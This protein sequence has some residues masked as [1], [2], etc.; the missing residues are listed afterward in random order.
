MHPSFPTTSHAMTNQKHVEQLQSLS[1]PTDIKTESEP[2]GEASDNSDSSNQ[3]SN[4]DNMF[5]TSAR[6]F[7]NNEPTSSQEDQHKIFSEDS[8]RQQ[9]LT[10][11]VSMSPPNITNVSASLKAYADR[12]QADYFRYRIAKE[13]AD[14]FYNRLAVFQNTFNPFRYYLHPLALRGLVPPQE[15][16]GVD[17]SLKNMG[18]GL[19]LT[20]NLPVPSPLSPFTP[21]DDISAKKRS[22]EHPDMPESSLEKKQKLLLKRKVAKKLNFDEE[23]S[24]PVSGT[25]IRQLGEGEAMPEVRKGRRENIWQI[26]SP[27]DCGIF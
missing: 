27:Q 9:Y 24:S 25:L 12:M 13:S 26:R 5:H 14:N 23:T 22:L 16:P 7:A 6:V 15:S 17:L 8:P 20:K 19:P 11:P 3:D 10:P 2:P 18:M 1:P 4:M 21:L